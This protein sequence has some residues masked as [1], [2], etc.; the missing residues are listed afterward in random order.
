MQISSK[1]CREVLQ[2]ILMEHF[3]EGSVQSCSIFFSNSK[4]VVIQLH[5]PSQ[6]N[7]QNDYKVPNH[8]EYCNQG[9]YYQFSNIKTVLL[10]S[11]NCSI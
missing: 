4:Y 1:T 11:W 7:G 9:Q 6:Q 8:S 3:L 2:V 5:L 10:W